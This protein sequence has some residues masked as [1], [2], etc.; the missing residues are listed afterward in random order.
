[1]AVVNV[2]MQELADAHAIVVDLDKDHD[3]VVSCK[4]GTGAQMMSLLDTR[5]VV[6]GLLTDALAQLDAIEAGA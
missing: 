6:R 4:F 1:M 3:Q 5:D 2:T